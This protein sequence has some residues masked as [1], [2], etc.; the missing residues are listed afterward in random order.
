MRIRRYVAATVIALA[1]VGGLAAAGAA[2]V[3]PNPFGSSNGVASP[4][5]KGYKRPAAPPVTS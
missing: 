4:V 3:I 2:G 1:L 5:E